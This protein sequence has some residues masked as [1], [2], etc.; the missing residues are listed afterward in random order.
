MRPAHP[1]ARAA[2][3]LSKAGKFGPSGTVTLG[4]I[5]AALTR[6][7]SY[8]LARRASVILDSKDWPGVD[9]VEV[10]MKKR[11]KIPQVRQHIRDKATIDHLTSGP[12]KPDMA[13]RGE[14][15]HREFGEDSA[16]K[17]EKAIHEEWTPDKGG[18][19]RLL[20]NPS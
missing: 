19:A 1:R 18:L 6:P 12:S 2:G 10:Q 20:R 7:A 3:P 16:R 5:N 4:Y 17:L 14:R 15:D 13:P 11:S 9:H 8:G